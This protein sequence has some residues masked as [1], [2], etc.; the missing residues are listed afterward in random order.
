MDET[1]IQEVKEKLIKINEFISSLDVELKSTAVSLLMPLY[2]EENDLKAMQV[3]AEADNPDD[4]NLDDE[5]TFFSSFDHEKPA[6]N[7]L[8][9]TARLYSQYGVYPIT[10]EEVKNYATRLGITIAPRVD[11]TLRYAARDEKNLFRQVGRGWEP[12]LPGESFFKKTYN[13]KKGNKPK[14][15][16]EEDN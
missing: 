13:V 2:F 15:V 1:R 10:P 12:T 14:P 3:K 8:M 7:V 16:I 5:H 11:N 4:S 9:I 6:D